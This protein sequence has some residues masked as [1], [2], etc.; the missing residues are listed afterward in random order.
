MNTQKINEKQYNCVLVGDFNIDLMH[1]GTDDSVGE[2]VDHM[3]AAGFKFR[4]IQP[5]R[6]SHTRASLIDLVMDNMVGKT[7][8]SGV[9]TTQ[10][11]GTKGWTD[12][13]PIYTII[14]RH[15]PRD[16]NPTTRTRRKINSTTT[17]A[18]RAKLSNADFTEAYVSDPNE[19]MDKMMD[20]IMKVH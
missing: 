9:I 20:T 4:L 8:T 13:F 15:V 14:R 5:T 1:Y 10:L 11:H 19:A 16:E 7:E 6:I 17:A 3:V 18:F 2:Y 12:H